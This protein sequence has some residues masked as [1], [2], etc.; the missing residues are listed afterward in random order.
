MDK[1]FFRRLEERPAESSTTNAFNDQRNDIELLTKRK[2]RRDRRLHPSRTEMMDTN[3]R[4]TGDKVIDR[5]VGE[6]DGDNPTQIS[7]V[8]LRHGDESKGSFESTS[9]TKRS[10]GIREILDKLNPYK[11]N[12][13]L[14]RSRL[15]TKTGPTQ[16][17]EPS[18]FIDDFPEHLRYSRM[19]DLGPQWSKPLMYPKS[20]KKRT[21]VEWQDLERLD[22]GQFLND[23]LIAFYL[24]YLERK[25]E[26][27]SPELAKKVYFFN[28]YFFTSL[29][30]TSRGRRGINYQAVRNWTRMIDIFTYDYV[31][32]PIN[33]SAHW[34][35]AII[36]NLPALNRNPDPSGDTTTILPVEDKIGGLDGADDD[37]MPELTSSLSNTRSRDPPE[38]VEGNEKPD[39]RDTRESFAEMN[40]LDDNNNST[41]T[42]EQHE[43]I[44]GEIEAIDSNAKLVPD[45][46]AMGERKS[47][48]MDQAEHEAHED[49]FA[50]D[51]GAIEAIAVETPVRKAVGSTKKGKRKSIPPMKTLDPDQPAIIILDSLG[52]SHSPTVR[53]LKDYLHEEAKD[54]RG[55][56]Y[57]DDGQLKGMTAKQIPQQDNF[58][59]C[60]LF[61]LGYLEKFVDNPREFVVKILRREYD[62]K[63]DWPKLVPSEMR[64]NIRGL[65]QG[66]HASQEDERSQVRRGSAR[67]IGK[68]HDQTGHVP[69]SSPSRETIPVKPEGVGI[70]ERN[71]DALVTGENIERTLT[72][73]EVLDPAAR[74]D[75]PEPHAKKIKETPVY[76][77]KSGSVEILPAS[78]AT[79]E[80]P[81]VI[82]DSQPEVASQQAQSEGVLKHNV[83]EKSFEL[84][85]EVATTPPSPACKRRIPDPYKSLSVVLSPSKRTR[86]G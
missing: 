29:T 46:E 60:G 35:V 84:P 31:V 81:F 30:N 27:G 70:S 77:G 24:R 32:V 19:N 54:K 21:T 50:E 51:E 79:I 76:A 23:N 48:Q 47:L 80:S 86:R 3:G 83:R 33:E 56:M 74:V 41:L 64:A 53:I 28:T 13:H 61:L 20:G 72:P 40:L 62:E 69:T 39:E 9:K 7:Q 42:V 63:M 68:D 14:T 15:S 36:C 58:C 22:D 59:D 34:Y 55:G 82:V 43:D 10:G 49:L 85:A 38:P 71:M 12:P 66:L 67:N 73:K 45:R 25:L 65:I 57:W 17:K 37:R 26:D 75:E 2:D 18:L 52:L 1:I 5:L 44:Q 6:E 78:N 4:R 16:A 11:G 8:Q